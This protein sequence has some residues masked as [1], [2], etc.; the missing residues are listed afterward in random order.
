MLPEKKIYINLSLDKIN[1]LLMFKHH[2]NTNLSK[3]TF[4]TVK[5]SR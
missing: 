4:L 2:L 1:K 5:L 3:Y